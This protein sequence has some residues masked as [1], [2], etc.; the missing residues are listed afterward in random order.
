M[1]NEIVA[2]LRIGFI[3]GG[4]IRNVTAESELL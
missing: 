3:V 1:T 4:M 2:R